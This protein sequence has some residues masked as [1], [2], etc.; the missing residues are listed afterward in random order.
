MAS[1]G[2]EPFSPIF[3]NGLDYVAHLG[4]LLLT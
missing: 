1:M 4:S 2:L 3:S